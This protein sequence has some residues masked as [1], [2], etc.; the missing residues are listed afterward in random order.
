GCLVWLDQPQVP[1]SERRAG[2]KS[3]CLLARQPIQIE[4]APEPRR[5]RPEDAY[6]SQQQNQQD[7]RDTKDRPDLMRRG[8]EIGYCDLGGMRERTLYVAQIAAP[9]EP[10][11]RLDLP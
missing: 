8:V 1:G 5:R 11:D 6:G 3:D 7:G 4:P 10:F 9:R 2:R